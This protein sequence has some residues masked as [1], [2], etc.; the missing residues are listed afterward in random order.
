MSLKVADTVGKSPFAWGR[1]QSIS[2]TPGTAE[3]PENHRDS[4]GA[5][6]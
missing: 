2:A 6:M 1:I 5:V 4:V 3:V